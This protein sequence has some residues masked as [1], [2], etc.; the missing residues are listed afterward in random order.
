MRDRCFVDY[1]KAEGVEFVELVAV[2][3]NLGRIE[4]DV[5][6]A[7]GLFEVISR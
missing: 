7:V 5:N 6:I 4:L 3:F 1:F 2:K